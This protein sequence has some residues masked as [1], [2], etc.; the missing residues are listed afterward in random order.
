M[1]RPKIVLTTPMDRY[2][3]HLEKE[4]EQLREL[5]EEAV[6]GLEWFIEEYPELD[7]KAD[8]EKLNEWK[9]QLKSK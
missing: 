8:Y 5:L 7:H 2:A 9:Q 3:D 1:K 6:I 4:N